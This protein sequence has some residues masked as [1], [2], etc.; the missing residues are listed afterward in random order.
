[1]KYLL[2][3]LAVVLWTG[4]PIVGQDLVYQPV[5][6]A[7]GGNSLNYGWLLNA[8][9]AQNGFT[10]P[11]E[12]GEEEDQLTQFSESLNRQ[13]L[14]QLSRNILGDQFGEAGLTEGTYQFGD[15]QIDIAPGLDGLVITINDLG[16]GGHTAIT[17]PYL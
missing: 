6:P 12:A 4:T 8:A 2:I 10:D 9:N 3:T 11:N 7:F 16:T 1:M 14:S 5:N 15:F 17:I 13:L